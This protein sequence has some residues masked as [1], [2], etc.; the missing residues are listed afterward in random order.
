MGDINDLQA[1]AVHDESVAELDRDAAGIIQRRSPDLRRD[2]RR[3]RIIEVHH[4]QPP[5]AKHVGEGADE[6]NAASAVQMP[7]GIEG[8]RPL[9]EIIVGIAIEQRATPGVF[10]FG[11]GLPTITRPSILSAT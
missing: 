8:Q 11:S 9:Q 7:V 6:S 3:E 5:V 10:V 1:V 2:L 4:H